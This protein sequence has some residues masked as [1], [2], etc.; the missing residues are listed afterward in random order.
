MRS[1]ILFTL[2]AV[3]AAPAFAEDMLIPNEP[4]VITRDV[5]TVQYVEHNR[6]YLEDIESNFG[7]FSG[8]S[9]LHTV[10]EWSPSYLTIVE[11]RDHTVHVIY[12]ETPPEYLGENNG[13][14][15]VAAHAHIYSISP[16]DR[17][18]W[19]DNNWVELRDKDADMDFQT[20]L[21]VFA[22]NKVTVVITHRLANA[23]ALPVQTMRILEITKK[24]RSPLYG[25]QTMRHRSFSPVSTPY[26]RVASKL[27]FAPALSWDLGFMPGIIA[28]ASEDSYIPPIP[29]F[30]FLHGNGTAYNVTGASLWLG[31]SRDTRLR[32]GKI[33]V[34]LAV[35]SDKGIGATFQ[36][37]P[38][39]IAFGRKE[40]WSETKAYTWLDRT[41]R[42][43]YLDIGYNVHL[44]DSGVAHGP[45]VQ[46]SICLVHCNP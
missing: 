34:G 46:T 32:F 39:S 19:R 9:P 8:W 33:G 7:H 12:S 38:V 24:G 36:F 20:T 6:E 25:L 18:S 23:T 22:L 37:S 40:R 10:I 21:R 16:S 17:S 13:T 27:R 5:L 2:L 3:V 41:R 31:S 35:H 1:R 43:V 4:P 11:Y 14:I 44:Y 15:R 30:S 45:Y 42:R 26:R 29:G 28:V